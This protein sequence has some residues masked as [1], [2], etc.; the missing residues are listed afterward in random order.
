LYLYINPDNANRAN[1]KLK[2]NANNEE[3]V[4]EKPIVPQK[5]KLNMGGAK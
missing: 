3:I 4:E 5:R 2:K 1:I